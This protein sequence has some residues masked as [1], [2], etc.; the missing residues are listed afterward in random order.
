[1]SKIQATYL[2]QLRANPD[3]TV[4]V[5]IHTTDAAANH[6][7]Q[8]KQL[9]LQVTRTFSLIPSLAAIGPAKAVISLTAEAWVTKV[10]PDQAMKTMD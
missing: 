8:V 1:M 3:E 5:I 4:Q 7:I 10:E 9:G 2:E 6:Q